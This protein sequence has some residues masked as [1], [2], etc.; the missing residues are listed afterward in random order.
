[1]RELVR[2]GRRVRS[3]ESGAGERRRGSAAR[4][5]DGRGATGGRCLTP[6]SSLL[7]PHSPRF[8]TASRK[9]WK[10][11]ARYSPIPLRTSKFRRTFAQNAG[12]NSLD[13]E[14]S[15]LQIPPINPHPAVGMVRADSSGVQSGPARNRR[16]RFPPL[17]PVKGRSTRRMNHENVRTCGRGDRGSRF[18]AGTAVRTVPLRVSYVLR[19]SSTLSSL[20]SYVDSARTA[21]RPHLLQRRACDQRVHARVRLAGLPEW[22]SYTPASGYRH[23]PALT[24]YGG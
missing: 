6:H 21:T 24:Y 7:T 4:S 3:E 13:R 17:A 16:V 22:Y 9:S 8:G 14:Q 12:R 1:M 20:P 2:G 11:R 10:G 18:S 15:R 23:Y 5:R 19:L